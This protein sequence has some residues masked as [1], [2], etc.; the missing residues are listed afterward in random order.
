M[1]NAAI[2]YEKQ[3]ELNNARMGQ[4]GAERFNVPQRGREDNYLQDGSADNY[5]DNSEGKHTERLDR[6]R[7]GSGNDEM[8]NAKNLAMDAVKMTNPLGAFSL[9]KQISPLS[10]IPYFAA[11]GAAI[12]KD[13]SDLVLIGSLPGLGTAIT[14]MCSIFIFMMMALVGAGEKRKLVN[15]LLKRGG[16]LL[17]GTIIEF[18]PGLSFIP[19]ETVTIVIIYFQ[20]L[21]ERKHAGE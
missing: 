1:G 8:K 9:M 16:I 6:A 19:I 11:F 12:L 17:T 14:I 7:A 3:N 21:S 18:I 10:D 4:S 20:V 13:L 5:N 15:G 2:D